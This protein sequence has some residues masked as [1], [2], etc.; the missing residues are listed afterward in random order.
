MI[1]RAEKSP[2]MMQLLIAEQLFSSIFH[3]DGV[4]SDMLQSEESHN[5]ARSTV[6]VT[7]SCTVIDLSYCLQKTQVTI[8]TL[9]G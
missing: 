9:N 8:P 2:A 6:V 3:V 1:T 7:D 4:V 5:Y